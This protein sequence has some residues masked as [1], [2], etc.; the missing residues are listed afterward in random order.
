VAEYVA[1]LGVQ[2]VSDDAA[3]AKLKRNMTEVEQAGRRTASAMDAVRSA[4][5]KIGAAYTAYRFADQIKEVV[6][7]AARYDT[8]GIAM[9]RAGQNIGASGRVLGE[10][11]A[12]LQKTGISMLESRQSIVSMIQA[13]VD[14]SK[15]TQLARIAQ[16][17][18]IVANVNSSE[19]FNRLVYGIKTGQPEIL[20]TMGLNVNFEKSYKALADSMHKTVGQLTTQEK[21]QARV[22]AVTIEA[23]SI[24]GLYEKAMESA[25]KQLLSTVRYL[26]DVKVKTG[27]AFQPAFTSAVFGYANALKFAGEHADAIGDALVFLTSAAIAAGL[28]KVVALIYELAVAMKAAQIAGK[29][30]W[31]GLV[32]TA[33]TGIAAVATVVWQRYQAQI[34]GVTEEHQ[35]LAKSYREVYVEM[36]GKEAGAV[37]RGEV[38]ASNVN[39]QQSKLASMQTSLRNGTPFYG[40][41]P[42]TGTDVARQYQ[43]VLRAQQAVADQA[44]ETRLSHMDDAIATEVKKETDGHKAL[45]AGQK[46][47][48]DMMTALQTGQSVEWVQK[49]RQREE[50]IL[51]VQKEYGD[52]KAAELRRQLQIVDLIEAAGGGKGFERKS[53]GQKMVAAWQANRPL[54]EMVTDI[55]TGPSPQQLHDMQMR[56]DVAKGQMPNQS[57]Y[58]QFYQAAA[59]DMVRAFSDAFRLIFTEGLNGFKGMFDA[60]GKIALNAAA[61]IAGV[62]LAKGLG[63]DKVLESLA[64]GQSFKQATKNLSGGQQAGLAGL[65]GIGVGQATNSPIAGMLGGAASG[66]AM[67]NPVAAV[68]GGVAG[69]VSGLIGMGAKAAEEARKFREARKAWDLAFEEFGKIGSLAL[70]QLQTSQNALKKSYEEFKKGLDE[71]YAK[72]K[73]SGEYATRMAALYSAYVAAQKELTRLFEV[74]KRLAF[75]ELGARA[76][77]AAG[78]VNE[79]ELIRL[80]IGQ[81]QE[82]ADLRAKGYGAAYEAE[83]IR[84]QQL[85]KEAV[86]AAQSSRYISAAMDIEEKMY[87]TRLRWAGKTKEADIAAAGYTFTRATKEA[88]ALWKAGTIS[89]ELYQQWLAFLKDEYL[90]T[91]QDIIDADALRVKGMKEDLAVRELYV[92][93]MGMEADAMQFRLGQQREYDQAMKDGMDADYLRRLKAVQDAER[94]AWEAAQAHGRVQGYL[95]VVARIA[96]LQGKPQVAKN[97]REQIA[98]NQELF[99]ADKLV[100]AGII[101]K[102]M[103]DL[104][105]QALID[106]LDPALVALAETVAASAGI[107]TEAAAAMLASIQGIADQAMG[108]LGSSA[109]QSSTIHYGLLG[110][111]P[112]IAN[113]PGFAGL[114]GSETEGFNN[115]IGYIGAGLAKLPLMTPAEAEAFKGW[116]TAV[117]PYVNAYKAAHPDWQ[118]PSGAAA[119]E[120]VNGANPYNQAAGASVAAGQAVSATVTDRTALMLVDYTRQEVALLARIAENTAAGGSGGGVN[121]RMSNYFGSDISPEATDRI[122]RQIERDLDELFGGKVTNATLS[123]GSVVRA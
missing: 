108:M 54:R 100:K 59:N 23:R 87:T 16:N 52:K 25:G 66:I 67:G 106:S 21:M 45:I 102:E 122:V 39:V 10:L 74:Q 62:W 58:T 101:T 50:Q 44:A 111:A 94:A 61:S 40:G 13:Q 20:R 29:G 57:D 15:A 93:G 85:E 95:G 7:L 69:L 113:T 68:V 4:A 56:V 51:A 118:N 60:I 121:I 103:F 77:A 42:A 18:A 86:L 3:W 55:P 88:E 80:L 90:Q 70:T 73:E 8:L 115:I 11:Q 81:E 116:M 104:L 64:A 76:A 117:S 82:L 78:R 114:G 34:R 96:E 123:T 37:A 31:V 92:A 17:A 75:E 109:A 27:L 49:Q 83:V 2:I 43:E 12:A 36:F 112:G 120:A 14:L 48:Q 72:N 22:N 91:I 26:E 71:V 1:K 41:K 63:L 97:I 9:V 110:T 30:G 24:T 33:V 5:L 32:V 105:A 79:A 38:L 46:E 35:R 47:Y 98:V 99:E 6:M 107:I 53:V 65:A 19:A 89:F 84:I 28:A 119:G